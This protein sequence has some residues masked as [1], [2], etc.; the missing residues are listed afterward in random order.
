[1]WDTES[2]SSAL[3]DRV[4]P[5]LDRAVAELDQPVPEIPLSAAEVTALLPARYRFDGAAEWIRVGETSVGG[6]PIVP[7]ELRILV[8]DL[9]VSDL[10]PDPASALIAEL[11]DAGLFVTFG[12]TVP[13]ATTLVRARYFFR[14]DDGQRHG[15]VIA[16]RRLDGDLRGEVWPW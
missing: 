5:E 1:M 10:G 16:V 2:M 12:D 6:G 15:I 3:I 11:T 4:V 7:H 13:Q 14:D 8:G 9:D